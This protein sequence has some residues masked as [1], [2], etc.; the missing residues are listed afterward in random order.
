MNE[1]EQILRNAIEATTINITDPEE[2]YVWV[3]AK[4]MVGCFIGL[5]VK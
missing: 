4:A 3:I 2:R 1:W 5:F